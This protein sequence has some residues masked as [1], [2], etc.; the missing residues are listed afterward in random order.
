MDDVQL[1]SA[2]GLTL[3]IFDSGDDRFVPFTKVIDFWPSQAV[4][5]AA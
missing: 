1:V 2:R 3:W 4:G 5:S